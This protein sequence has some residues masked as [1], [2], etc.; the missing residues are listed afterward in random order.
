M[1]KRNPVLPASALVLA[2]TGAACSTTSAPT[3]L[4]FSETV[5]DTF[6]VAA[7]ETLSIEAFAGSIDVRPG[8]PGT[9][10]VTA[11]KQARRLSDL[12]LITL[13]MEKVPNRVRIRTANPSHV[14]NASVDLA[15]TA[16]PDILPVITSGAG[17]TR[18]EGRPAGPW[19]FAVGA[20]DLTLVLPADVGTVVD[21]AVGAG[22][23]VSDFTVN[24]TTTSRTAVG[25]IGSG[26]QGSI[27]AQVGAGTLR[28]VA[29]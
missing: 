2:L 25:T 18:Y 6:L 28:L 4:P 26:P 29:Q 7:A 8:A 15:I 12:R 21:L 24:G 19:V 1:M 27:T 22:S 14:A 20:G 16:P 23:I 11:V 13:E 9:V 3:G 10:R 5:A 17:P